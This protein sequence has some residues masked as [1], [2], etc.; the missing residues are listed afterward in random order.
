MRIFFTILVLMFIFGWTNVN[1]VG[2]TGSGT[3]TDPYQISTAAHLALL[4]TNVNAGTSYAG[5][6]FKLMNN[7]SLSTSPNWTPIGKVTD[8]SPG[9]GTPFSC[10]FN[11]NDFTITGLTIAVT[12]TTTQIGFG[13]FGYVGA[14]GTVSNL[15]VT[16]VSR[17]ISIAGKKYVGGL[18][19][20]N[21]GTVDSYSTSGMQSNANLGK[22]IKEMT[23][24]EKTRR[25]IVSK[26]LSQDNPP[27][28]KS[29]N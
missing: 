28:A 3:S 16:G 4:A 17:T 15:N 7:I 26:L 10:N 23:D 14:I 19:G 11:G 24:R 21:Q 8:L 18:I 9:T 5:N 29:N 22:E 12:A 25:R 1:A 20:A 13:L 2:W 27:N 6:Y